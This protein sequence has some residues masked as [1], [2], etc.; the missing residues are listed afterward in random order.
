MMMAS[1]RTFDKLLPRITFY[2]RNVRKLN[3]KNKNELMQVDP[4]TLYRLMLKEIYKNVPFKG[5]QYLY[6]IVQ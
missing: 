3:T 6:L 1:F 2:N 4:I 5:L